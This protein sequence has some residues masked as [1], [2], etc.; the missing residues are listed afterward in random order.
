MALSDLK[1][2]SQ[3]PNQVVSSSDARE[4]GSRNG[5]LARAAKGPEVQV[6]FRS[7]NLWHYRNFIGIA[8]EII[9]AMTAVFVKWVFWMPLRAH[10]KSPIFD[11]FVV[12]LVLKCSCIPIYIALLRASS[13]INNS[14]LGFFRYALRA[15]KVIRSTVELS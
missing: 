7:T 1:V 10:L 8:S 15:M 14:K 13:P 12:V 4:K 9:Y 2:S 5:G 6:N 3:E 11:Y